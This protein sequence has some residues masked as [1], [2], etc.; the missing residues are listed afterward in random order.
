MNKRNFFDTLYD[1]FFGIEKL[2]K[3]NEKL[4]KE[5]GI[6]NQTDIPKIEVNSDNSFIDKKDLKFEKED[7]DKK[8]LDWFVKIDK[9]YI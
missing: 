6:T 3:E 7:R 9:L 1:D 4:R 8:M 5:L 2:E